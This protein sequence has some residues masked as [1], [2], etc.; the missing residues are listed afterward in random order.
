M[1]HVFLPLAAVL[2]S[3]SAITQVPKDQLDQPPAS[4]KHFTIQ[5]TGG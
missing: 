3:T 2:L 5:S 4:A 1:R